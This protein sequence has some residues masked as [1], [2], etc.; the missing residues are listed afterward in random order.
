[1]RLPLLL[2]LAAS[3]GA[4][5]A[6]AVTLRDGTYLR[7]RIG[8]IA[9]G[10]LEIQVMNGVGPLSIP[11]V[12]VESFRTDEAVRLSGQGGAVLD[13]VASAVAG[14]AGSSGGGETFAL[15]ERLNFGV[16]L[17]RGPWKSPRLAPGRCR[18][19][20]ISR[21]VPA[22]LKAA[23]SARVSKPRVPVPRTP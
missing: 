7:G 13:G 23:A 8:R 2:L 3:P 11:L 1:M 17:G 20:S 5:F 21:G 14:R 22:P 18:P 19:T 10:K 4:L 9:E 12:N 16:S 15:N 6:D